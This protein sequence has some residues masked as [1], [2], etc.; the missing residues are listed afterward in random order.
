MNDTEAGPA[1]S[2]LSTASTKGRR[3]NA[4]EWLRD[5]QRRSTLSAKAR[6]VAAVL[7]A[8]MDPDGASCHPSLDTIARDAGYS[9]RESILSRSASKG[10]NAQ[11][12]PLEELVRGGWLKRRLRP[13]DTTQY[14]ATVPLWLVEGVPDDVEQGVP[15]DVEHNLANDLAI[16]LA[17]DLPHGGEVDP[18]AV[19]YAEKI[20]RPDVDLDRP[21]T[22]DAL[23]AIAEQGVDPTS[24]ARYL[25]GSREGTYSASGISEARLVN[26]ARD[27]GVVRSTLS[28]AESYA[29]AAE[30]L[31]RRRAAGD[32][33]VVDLRREAA[34]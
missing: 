30:E 16:D 9:N 24:V 4:H 32:A 31:R 10:R 33:E 17:N 28:H 8:R 26:I 3:V 15:D 7:F 22:V 2:G 5:V 20:G 12:G 29:A 19:A 11:V 27:P 18:R 25:D 21:K 13:G 34:S 6:A 23:V 14:E 1:T